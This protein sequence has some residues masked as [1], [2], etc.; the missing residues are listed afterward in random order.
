MQERF[1]DERNPSLWFVGFKF[2]D[3]DDSTE[4]YYR[5]VIPFVGSGLVSVRLTTQFKN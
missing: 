4:S 2:D 3:E 1:K 5:D